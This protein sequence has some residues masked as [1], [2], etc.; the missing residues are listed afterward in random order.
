MVFLLFTLSYFRSHAQSK[1][2]VLI[3][4]ADDMG[5]SDP[6]CYGNPIIA[7]P[8]IDAMARD[9]M[10][11][12][13]AYA[14]PVCAPTRA[15][16]QTGQ[17]SARL[18]LTDV[19]NGHRRP[20]GKLIPPEIYW[21]LK[22]EHV[23]IAEAIQS[24]G[25]VSGIF[26]KWNLGYDDNHQPDDQGYIYPQDKPIQGPYA[27][28]VNQW[29]KD[30]PQKGIGNQ[31]KECVQFIEQN[32]DRPFFCIASYNM[33]HTAPEARRELVDKYKKIVTKNRTIIDPVYAAMCETVDES[34]GLFREVLSALDLQNNTLVF[35]YSDNG[36]VVEERRYLFHGYEN[37]VT[38]N[39]PLRDE[40]GTL[41]EGGIRV[42]LIAVWP[43][44]IEKGSTNENV[45]HTIDFFPTILDLA[46]IKNPENKILDGISMMAL[47]MDKSFHT[48]R[49]LYWH[50][51][52][53]HHSTP[54]SA[55]RSGNYKLIHFY[56]TDKS[57]LYYL[58][59]DIGEQ[60]DLA[61][62]L[63]DI[64]NALQNKLNSWLKDVN[65]G[66]PKVNPFYDPARELI[67]GVRIPSER[68]K[69][70]INFGKE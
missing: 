62:S 29:I 51:P 4:L 28:K 10:K 3:I 33:V 13:N 44:K 64:K 40:K 46:D 7:T 49:D 11:F 39:W 60:Y 15:A 14:D 8:N 20:Y 23:T 63:S 58:V 68:L 21:R 61:D 54:A 37:L 66:M 70:G 52:H 24:A 18:Q 27:D 5:W 22:R 30:N 48:E 42:P 25:Y 34:V 36:G 41:Y 67:W 50:Y 31:F 57:E 12:T 65:A 16:L 56:E 45:V 59:N 6:S 69:E 1:P 43:G 55:I 47:L 2:N 9:G 17:Y 53:Y 19:P 35:F 32:E 38:N 26:G